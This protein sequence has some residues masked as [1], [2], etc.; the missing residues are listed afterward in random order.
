M[1]SVYTMQSYIAVNILLVNLEKKNKQQIVS[2]NI[3]LL[4]YIIKEE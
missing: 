2:V 3:P 4:K 1:F